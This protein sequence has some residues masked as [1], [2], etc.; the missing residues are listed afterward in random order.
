MSLFHSNVSDFDLRLKKKKIELKKNIQ[1]Q[2]P[3]GQPVELFRQT[4]FVDAFR[5]VVISNVL[6][7]DLKQIAYLFISLPS[8]SGIEI[9]RQNKIVS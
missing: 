7:V 1:A 5:P 8:F 4:E 3:V 6:A 2:I 9:I